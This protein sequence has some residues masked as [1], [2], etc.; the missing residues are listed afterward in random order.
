MY[1]DHAHGCSCV[2]ASTYF[3]TSY[4]QKLLI[5]GL[6]R[7]ASKAVRNVRYV[8][9]EVVLESMAGLLNAPRDGLQR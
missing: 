6:E 7:S 1:W 9:W 8:I 5:Q 4:N 2:I 3:N